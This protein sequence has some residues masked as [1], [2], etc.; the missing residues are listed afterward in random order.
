MSVDIRNAADRGRFGW[1]RLDLGIAQGWQHQLHHLN[2]AR[3]VITGEAAAV[4]VPPRL[5][6]HVR[7]R[8]ANGIR[9]HP[10]QTMPITE[11]VDR[12]QLLAGLAAQV[13]RLQEMAAFHAA[14]THR[15]SD[16]TGEPQTWFQLS[17]KAL[18]EHIGALAHALDLS[19]A[20][21]EQLW[22]DAA[23]IAAA[24][25]RARALDGD[26]LIEQWR[27]RASL[28]NLI[29][30][31]LPIDVLQGAGITSADSAAAGQLPPAPQE[32]IALAEN[33][34]DATTTST[35]DGDS[36]LDA[37]SAWAGDGAVIHTAI[38]HAGLNSDTHTAPLDEATD[39]PS[40]PLHL[41]TN[42]GIDP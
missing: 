5:I 6:E 20:E 26:A 24:T 34:T 37:A 12:A 27:S 28:S 21:R 41:T 38:E 18:R 22:P 32:L 1:D 16:F 40:H 42:H 29:A 10:G 30:E 25:T 4:G 23:S 33:A 11:V 7:Q 39:P 31:S 36:T 35:A 8:G 15:Y 17:M 3:E 14:Y 2:E 9:W 19:P 13:G